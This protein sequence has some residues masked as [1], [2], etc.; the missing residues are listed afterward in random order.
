[1]SDEANRDKG[2]FCRPAVRSRPSFSMWKTIEF[3]PS[4]FACLPTLW[5]LAVWLIFFL[6][7]ADAAKFLQQTN[8]AYPAHARAVAVD[9]DLSTDVMISGRM[10]GSLEAR[11]A[12]LELMIPGAHIEGDV[13][14]S[15]ARDPISDSRVRIRG[16]LTRSEDGDSYVFIREWSE[17]GWVG[18]VYLYAAAVLT[19]IIF[20][21]LMPGYVSRSVR[22]VRRSFWKSLLAGSIWFVLIPIGILLVAATLVGLPAALLAGMLYGTLLYVSKVVVAL[23]FG[24]VLLRRRGQHSFGPAC[25]ALLLGMLFLYLGTNLPIVGP[26]ITWLIVL[27]G[28][29]ALLLA[30]RPVPASATVPP[31]LPLSETKHESTKPPLNS[32]D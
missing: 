25:G 2:R 27:T 3:Y 18:Q 21:G 12:H 30:M 23:A 10:G 6:P 28:L 8:F 19:G 31:P 29:G 7:A 4:S 11:E 15:A 26:W 24:G 5:L 16:A 13:R 20:M 22:L 9:G 14:H 17:I 32:G 1:M